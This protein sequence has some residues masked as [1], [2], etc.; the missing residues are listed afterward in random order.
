MPRQCI[1]CCCKCKNQIKIMKHPGNEIGKG[2]VTELFGYACVI[3]EAIF[4]DNEHGECELFE[5]KP[6]NYII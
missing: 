4:K 1:R 2:P 6:L 3:E 5:L